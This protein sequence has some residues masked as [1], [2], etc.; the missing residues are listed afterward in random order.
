[1]VKVSKVGNAV[2]LTTV[3]ERG[4]LLTAVTLDRAYD[5]GKRLRCFMC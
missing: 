1:V 4:Q 2:G 3:F 5:G